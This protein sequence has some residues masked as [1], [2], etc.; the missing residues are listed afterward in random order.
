MRSGLAIQ[1]VRFI[2]NTLEG[3]EM[4]PG[5]SPHG[6]FKTRDGWI[7]LVVMRNAEFAPFCDAIERPDMADDSRY[8]TA[9]TRH[10]HAE[11]LTRAI[12]EAMSAHP[13]AHWSA[14]LKE[15]GIVHEV[16]NDYAG[17]LAHPQA[18]ADNAVSWLRQPGLEGPAPVPNLAG[19][20]P[21]GDGTPRG[22]APRLGQHTRE[23]LAGLNFDDDRILALARDGIVAG[24]DLPPAAA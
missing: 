7:T 8:A 13:S 24:P 9:V 17:F 18:S 5:A 3:G 22:T 12:N 15:A 20:T 2:A 19:V 21:P 6:V 14:R 10:A 23:I 16:L 1:S 4:T 11:D